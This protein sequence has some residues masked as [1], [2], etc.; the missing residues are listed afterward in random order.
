M[1]EL[2]DGPATKAQACA[3]WRFK[4]TAEPC[5]FVF[6]NLLDK[7]DLLG[8][9]LVLGMQRALDHHTEITMAFVPWVI[10]EDVNGKQTSVCAL[11]AE[12]DVFKLEFLAGLVLVTTSTCEIVAK[13]FEGFDRLRREP[14][15]TF[16]VRLVVHCKFKKLVNKTL[17][18]WRFDQGL[19]VS[20][21]ATRPKRVVR[22]H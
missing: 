3:P 14:L 19:E 9:G 15:E 18:F 16:Q 5:Q 12:L 21:L 4:H 17:F 7:F 22:V 2:S 10:D 6:R 8:D 11:F 20:F 13:A 1:V